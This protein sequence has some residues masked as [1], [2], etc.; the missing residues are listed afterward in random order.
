[1]ALSRYALHGDQNGVSVPMNR[2]I[3]RHTK[4]TKCSR[5]LKGLYPIRDILFFVSIRNPWDRYISWYLHWTKGEM[6]LVE[7]IFQ[8]KKSLLLPSMKS[9]IDGMSDDL[10]L[11]YIRFENLQEDFD[12]LCDIL[13]IPKQILPHYNQSKRNHYSSYYSIDA[14]NF[15][16]KQYE[17][18]IEMF[19]YKFESN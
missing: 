13:D 18:D 7:F 6:S 17:E 14:R 4:F 1:M 9:F 10:S 19:K 15:I 8:H 12:D 3:A 5:I 16:A 11:H 2:T